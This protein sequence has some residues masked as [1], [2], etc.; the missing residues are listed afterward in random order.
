MSRT[1]NLICLYHEH[2]SNLVEAIKIATK[3]NFDMIIT[4]LTNPLFPR[5]KQNEGLHST[6]TR[7]E[8]ILDPVD[9][10]QRIIPK[11]SSYI[12]CDSPD[13]HIRRHSEFILQQELSFARH[14][15]QGGCSII[16]L[17]D[18]RTTC[19]LARHLNTQKGR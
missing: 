16:R 10:F 2:I 18:G 12:D 17:K 19:N 6:F 9:W 5:D 14:L 11:F 8:L 3:S 7:S 1:G 13:P 15:S 4:S